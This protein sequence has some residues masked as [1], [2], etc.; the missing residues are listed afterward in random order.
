[1][2]NLII[3]ALKNDQVVLQYVSADNI[4]PLFRLQGS[5][6][7]AVVI[8]LV[9]TTPIDTHDVVTDMD[10]HTV[11]ITTINLDPQTAW[12]TSQQIRRSLESNTTI[13]GIDRIRFETQATDVFEVQD[14][15]SVTQRYEM[16]ER[17]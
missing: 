11:E 2:I 8:Q 16:Y 10:L 1:M 15:F 3:N 17:R 13:S 4:Y 14:A 6:L 7:P 5:D 12:K 9:N